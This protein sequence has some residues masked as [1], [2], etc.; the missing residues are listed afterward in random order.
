MTRRETPSTSR[1][2][3]F[4]GREASF[5]ALSTI[6]HDLDRQRRSRGRHFFRAWLI[7]A[8]F[9]LVLTSVIG[10]RSDWPSQSGW[11]VIA[12]LCSLA[13]G[14][15][16]FP[17]IGVGLWFPTFRSRLGLVTVGLGTTAIA[18]LTCLQVAEDA[19]FGGPCPLLVWFAVGLLF[20]VGLGSGAFTAR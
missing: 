7:G 18:S 15:V 14:L 16:L 1:T 6:S 5:D 3:G 10:W 4:V 13:F 2:V 19:G 11:R 8:T 20:S 17:A 12:Q 9:L